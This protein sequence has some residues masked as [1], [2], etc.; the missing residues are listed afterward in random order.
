MRGRAIGFSKQCF[1][2]D[3][4][5]SVLYAKQ[6]Q[7]FELSKWQRQETWLQM[8]PA[9]KKGRL[10]GFGF[11]IIEPDVLLRLRTWLWPGLFHTPVKTGRLSA[12]M[13]SG[14]RGPAAFLQ[15]SD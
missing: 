9:I 3:Q 13:N 1:P 15:T 2:D 7:G 11:S 5:R 14:S 12:P 4:C 6:I 10:V 8:S